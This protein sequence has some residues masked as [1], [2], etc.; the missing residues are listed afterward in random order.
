M[1][2]K[3]CGEPAYGHS[4]A[5]PWGSFQAELELRE[6]ESKW[7]AAAAADSGN[8]WR[9]VVD[10]THI[11]GL[12]CMCNRLVLMGRRL[13]LEIDHRTERIE[14]DTDTI[15]VVD[16]L[17]VVLGECFQGFGLLNLPGCSLH[18]VVSLNDPE[19]NKIFVNLLLIYRM[20]FPGF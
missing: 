12:D 15:L 19:C 9:R 1:G 11:A 7:A 17:E 13:E 6:G 14:D 4:Q 16:P 18:C 2:N 10:S 3:H 5:L 20:Q 8:Q